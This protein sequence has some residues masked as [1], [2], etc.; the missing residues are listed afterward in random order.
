M[1]GRRRSRR[2]TTVASMLR[3]TLVSTGVH[4]GGR[5][6]RIASLSMKMPRHVGQRHARERRPSGCMA[7]PSFGHFHAVGVSSVIVSPFTRGS[8][9]AP[10]E[11]PD[12]GTE[13]EQ[14]HDDRGGALEG[15]AVRV[16]GGLPLDLAI[17][18]HVDARRGRP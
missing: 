7:V 6:R 4:H 10:R 12:D 2:T 13:D 16:E 17:L 8:A 5:P 1:R 15:E 18:D 11:R 9:S 3:I 14:S